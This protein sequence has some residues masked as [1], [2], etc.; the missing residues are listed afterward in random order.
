MYIPKYF[1]IT[2]RDEMNEII[3]SYGFAT[4]Y[5]HHQGCPYATHLPLLLNEDGTELLGHFAKGNK[6]WTDIVGQQVLVVFQGPHCYISPSWYETQDTVPTWN[7]V[8]VHV[9]GKIELMSDGDTRLM[10]SMKNLTLKYEEPSSDY[11][12]EEVNDTYIESLSKG[13]VGFILRIDEIQGKAK[14]SQNHP[15]ERIERVIKA[16]EKTGKSNEQA[17]SL[18]MAKASSKLED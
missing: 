5:S 12:L 10:E 16:L 6:Q 1:E 2:D 14:L 13:V 4:L 9:K 7:Y 17:I 3:H 18:C 15:K 8:T 11:S